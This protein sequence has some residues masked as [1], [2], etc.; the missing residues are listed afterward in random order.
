VLIAKTKPFK[1]LVFFLFIQVLISPTIVLS[2]VNSIN[3]LVAIQDL[4]EDDTISGELKNLNKQLTTLNKI[5][6]T[7]IK[8]YN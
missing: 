6:N 4:K 2:E 7:K 1:I 3:T 5:L 8:K